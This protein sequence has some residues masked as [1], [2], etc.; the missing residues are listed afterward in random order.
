[1]GKKGFTLVELIVSVGLLTLA[2]TGPLAVATFSLRSS[3]VSK[4]EIVAYNLA[5]E[6]IEYIKNKIDS[7]VF[8]PGAD[9]RDG[10]SECEL[11]AGC[12]VDSVSQNIV[13]CPGGTCPVLRRSAASG[14]YSHAAAS[15]DNLDT[16][17]RRKVMLKTVSGS[18]NEEKQLEVTISWP[19][20]DYTHSFS[21][22]TQVFKKR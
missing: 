20:R 17:F 6:G 10:L 9:W 11:N 5:E 13:S 22:S 18:G 15:A 8:T 19:E 7:N 12:D 14:L 21:I 3:S 2:I 1:M 4:N 16:I